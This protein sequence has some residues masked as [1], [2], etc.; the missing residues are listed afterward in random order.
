MHF[1]AVVVQL[2]VV[3]TL[4]L[5]GLHKIPGRRRF[6]A[7]LTGLGVPRR[8]AG[9]VTAVVV[10]AEVA[11]AAAL[12]FLP[13]AL[14]A[15]AALAAGVVFAGAGLVALRR[16]LHLPCACFGS[17]SGPS[18]ELGRR[19]VALLPL[20]LAG[21]LIL[22]AGPGRA[23]SPEAGLER[24]ALGLLAAAVASLVPVAIEG[25]RARADRLALQGV[26]S[27]VTGAA[28]V[29]GAGVAR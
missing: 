23:G 8:R 20:W 29:A 16:R 26:L 13:D 28:G 11:S 24:V 6:A 1:A 3:S 25:R 22:A 18:S 27:A 10:G 9:A 12:P 14:Q 21:A 5:A 7:T 17:L 4:A 15:A 2:A 19:Q